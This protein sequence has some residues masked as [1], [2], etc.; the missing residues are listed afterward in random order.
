[1]K[2]MNKKH[3]NGTIER[4]VL[5]IRRCHTVVQNC[6]WLLRKGKYIEHTPVYISMKFKCSIMQCQTFF[7]AVHRILAFL[8]RHVCT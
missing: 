5:V 7:E 4:R 6:G 8:A 1:M 3:K 2:K